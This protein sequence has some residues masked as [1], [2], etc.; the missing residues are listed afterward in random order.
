MRISRVSLCS[1]LSTHLTHWL[2]SGD[3][4]IMQKTVKL[5][6]QHKIKVGAHPGYPDVL[7]FGRREIQMDPDELTAMVR[8]QVGAL[9]GFLDAEGM[10]LHHVKPHGKL[11]GVCCRDYTVARAV[12]S[13]IP[14]GVPVFGLAGTN[15]EKAANDLGLPFWAEFYGDVKYSS[16][17]MLVIDRVKKPWKVEDVR[18]HISMQINSQSVKAT[19]GK[20]VK[21]PVKDYPIS[22]CC[23][24]DSPGCVEI[25]TEVKRVV[26]EFNKKHGR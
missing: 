14:T 17:G 7:G 23:H 16:D 21:L 26:D 22:V 20:V 19:D 4:L 9:K 6:K 25:V 18:D 3:P 15:M 11:Y 2:D 1:R 8:Y 12:M 13:G 5:C 24:S 10:Q